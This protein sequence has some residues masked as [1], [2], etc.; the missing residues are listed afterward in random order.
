MFNE[1]MVLRIQHPIQG[2]VNLLFNNPISKRCLISRSD[3]LQ[4]GLVSRKLKGLPIYDGFWLTNVIW[5]APMTK[6]LDAKRQ[7]AKNCG[8]PVKDLA[9]HR[10]QQLLPFAL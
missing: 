1:Y 10:H 5:V 2:E 9:G 6:Q 3:W 8:T 4:L 7:V